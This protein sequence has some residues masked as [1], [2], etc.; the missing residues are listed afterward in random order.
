MTSS[1][2]ITYHKFQ[3]LASTSRHHNKLFMST[4]IQF[5][6]IYTKIIMRLQQTTFLLVL[7]LMFLCAGHGIS[8]KRYGD[9]EIG[10][11]KSSSSSSSSSS[12]FK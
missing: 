10:S 12:S 3:E 6:S 11:L 7:Y 4:R 1:Q 5:L 2:E 9:G 8:S